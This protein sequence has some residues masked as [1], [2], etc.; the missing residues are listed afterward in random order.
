MT[1]M[2][3]YRFIL[4]LLGMFFTLSLRAHIDSALGTVNVSGEWLYHF[5]S[6]D[7][8]N[9]IIDSTD[10]DEP[11]G[12]RVA[13]DQGWHSG[14]RVSCTYNFCDSL[15][16]FTARWTHFPSLSEH[17]SHSGSLLMPIV[18]FPVDSGDGESGIATIR[19][20]FN[21][22]FVDLLFSR[23]I[24]R[25]CSFGLSLLGGVQLGYLGFFQ[26]IT[27][28]AGGAPSVHTIVTHSRLRGGGLEAGVSGFYN[29]WNC[30]SFISS[31][32]SSWLYSEVAVNSE[33]TYN[34]GEL[35]V[36]TESDPYWRLIPTTELRLGLSYARPLNLARFFRGC[37]CVHFDI[38]LGYELF[39]IQEGVERIFFIDDANPGGSYSQEM[40]LSLNGPYLHIGVS[41]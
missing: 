21:S 36:K 35:D 2:R 32:Q 5:L 18:T 6:V 39:I 10:V 26:E 13:N 41:Y 4:L 25:H 22:A 37:G 17:N 3:K 29:F 28:P 23:E 9:F 40:D 20:T 31:F 11:I 33:I 30:F 8:P 15:N 27:T 7:Q 34:Y 12:S 19:D 16:S 38:E 24:V 1:K 14:Y